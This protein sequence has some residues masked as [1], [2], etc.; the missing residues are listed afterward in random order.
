[1]TD[2][3]MQPAMAEADSFQAELFSPRDYNNTYYGGDAQPMQDEAA[4]IEWQVG[5]LAARLTSQLSMLGLNRFPSMFEAGCGPSVHHALALSPWALTIKMADYM[6]GNLA[7]VQNWRDSDP[8]AHDWSLFVRSI[9]AHEGINPTPKAIEDRIHETKAK[10]V[11]LGPLDLKRNIPPY[12][13][14]ALLVTSFFVA[15]SATDDIEEF[16]RMTANAFEAVEPG[17]L[18]V[19]AYLLS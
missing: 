12:S 2:V 18:F 14:V 19:A 6:P 15:D 7:E 10:I 3:L 8:Q 9:L 16:N 5:P 1:M 13:K 17:G 4:L 11:S